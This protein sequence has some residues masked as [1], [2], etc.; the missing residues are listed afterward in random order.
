MQTMLSN[1]HAGKGHKLTWEESKWWWTNAEGKALTVDGRVL[2][3]MEVS[4][5]EFVVP[6]PLDDLKVHGHVAT[7]PENG[8]I[9]DGY[10]DFEPRVMPNPNYSPVIFMRNI[11]ND[12]AIREVGPGTPYEIQYRYEDK[13]FE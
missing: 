7:N 3:T 11:L 10:F 4:G 1:G 8:R 6:L 2:S 5:S 9:Y 13:Y 12:A